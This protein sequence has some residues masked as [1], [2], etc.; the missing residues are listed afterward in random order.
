V[1]YLGPGVGDRAHD[2][3]ADHVG[4]VEQ[5]DG[6]DRV[7]GVRHPEPHAGLLQRR[8]DDEHLGAG[9]VVVRQGVAHGRRVDGV[10]G[11]DEELH[12]RFATHEEPARVVL[13]LD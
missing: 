7:V 9:K 11:E 4:R 8:R 12:G 6:A 3:A 13:P 5:P 2:L 1:A 10:R